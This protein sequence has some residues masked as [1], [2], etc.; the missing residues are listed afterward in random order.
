MDAGR[1]GTRS[2]LHVRELLAKVF[3]WTEGAY[4]SKR[5]TRQAE[6]ELT[7]KVSTAS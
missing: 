5:R 3:A 2:R 1:L 7:L 6:G 4:A